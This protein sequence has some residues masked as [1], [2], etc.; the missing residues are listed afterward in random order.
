MVL[1]CALL[2][3]TYGDSIALDR[4][5]AGLPIAPLLAV[6]DQVILR[7]DLSNP[8]GQDRS[9]EQSGIQ[10]HESSIANNVSQIGISENGSSQ[11]Y[12]G[13]VGFH[14]SG[15]SQISISQIAISQISHS[16]NG[17]LQDS[18]PHFTTPQNGTAQG[19]NFQIGSGQIGSAQVTQPKVSSIEISSTQIDSLQILPSQHGPITTLMGIQVNS[20]EIP[21]PSSI[22]LQQ[23]LSSH[24]FNLQNTTIP[25]WTEFL[26]G[27]TPFNLNI[28][29]IDRPTGQ[30]AVRAALR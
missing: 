30:L 12:S 4:M 29:I 16:E 6:P 20:S 7:G 15:T 9:P 1:G 14:Q 19:S 21:L 26:T 25:T 13:E 8:I 18:S 23:F 24:N 10:F 17:L 3:P 5:A 27:S 11:I 2:H 28:E 22:T